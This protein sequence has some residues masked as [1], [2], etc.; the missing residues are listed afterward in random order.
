MKLFEIS[1]GATSFRSFRSGNRGFLGIAAFAHF[2]LS[3]AREDLKDLPPPEANSQKDFV[4]ICRAV[5]GAG[6]T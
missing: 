6:A 4:K 3:R 1:G 5:Q 2:A